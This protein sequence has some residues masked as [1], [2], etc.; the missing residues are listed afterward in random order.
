[1]CVF[2]L[3]WPFRCLFFAVLGASRANLNGPMDA[4]FCFSGQRGTGFIKTWAQKAKVSQM[5]QRF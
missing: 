4:R 1:M 5:K 2:G 3:F